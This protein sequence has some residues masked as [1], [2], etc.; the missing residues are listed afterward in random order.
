MLFRNIFL[1]L[2]LFIAYLK[3]FTFL[4]Y[5]DKVYIAKNSRSVKLA[6][7]YSI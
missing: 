7:R 3:A 4:I 2:L 1:Y 5:G 6:K